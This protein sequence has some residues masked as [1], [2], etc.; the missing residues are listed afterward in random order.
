MNIL[1]VQG[2]F[3]NSLCSSRPFDWRLILEGVQGN[4]HQ[5]KCRKLLSPTQ[6][7]ILPDFPK[8]KFKVKGR[9]F[10]IVRGI[11]KEL[12][13]LFRWPGCFLFME[14]KLE[15]FVNKYMPKGIL[16]KYI[17]NIWNIIFYWHNKFIIGLVWKLYSIV[18][19][20]K[21]IFFRYKISADVIIS[22]IFCETRC[23][24]KYLFINFWI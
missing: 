16:A 12:K 23:G 3:L 21:W 13:P 24:L 1:S 19:Q 10:E 11:R 7:A 14:R 6:T 5:Q 17:S 15:L 4:Y 18:R 9:S 22:L 8:I 2:R 20:R